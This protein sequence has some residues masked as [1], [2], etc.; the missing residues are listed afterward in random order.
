MQA[1]RF[2]D[3]EFYVRPCGKNVLGAGLV[4]RHAF[5]IKLVGSRVDD[6]HCFTF[7]C[8]DIEA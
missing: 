8:S 5:S 1:H 7:H 3:S 6:I 4:D 2:G